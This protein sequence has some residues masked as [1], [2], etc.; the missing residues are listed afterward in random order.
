MGLHSL[1]PSLH[2]GLW[3]GQA[4][5]SNSALGESF[6]GVLFHTPTR[7]LSG[8]LFLCSHSSLGTP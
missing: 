3:L 2:R 7:V 5:L 6:L 1:W 4:N 8:A